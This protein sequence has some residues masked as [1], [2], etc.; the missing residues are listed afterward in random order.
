MKKGYGKEKMSYAKENPYY[1]SGSRKGGTSS[2]KVMS[3]GKKM[4]K[5]NPVKKGQ[6]AKSKSYAKENPVKGY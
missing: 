5:E 4:G 2:E 1:K 3:G 6:K